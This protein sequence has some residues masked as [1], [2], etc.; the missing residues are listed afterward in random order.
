MP[1]GPIPMPTPPDRRIVAFGRACYG[2]GVAG[3]GVQFFVNRAFVAVV[4]PTMPA[5]PY[6]TAVAGAALVLAGLAVAAA[7]KARGPA[8]WL[9]L[10]FLAAFLFGQLPSV[11]PA[12][13]VAALWTTPLKTLTFAGGA[14]ICAATLGGP[15]Q[16]DPF[17]RNFGRGAYGVTYVFF[18]IEHFLYVNFVASL[19]PH[20]IPGPVFWTYFAGAALIASGLG[21][22]TGIAA[23]L[24]AG[25]SGLM[26]FI[27][28][29][30]LHLPRAAVDPTGQQGNEVSSVVEALAF[31]GLGFV[32]W[33]TLPE[34]S[35]AA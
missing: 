14:W 11:A 18:G 35:R 9:G 4:L 15:H 8:F 6:W 26:V 33:R 22:L 32:L 27:W 23:R 2:L 20:W 21:L 7:W 25:L 34:K 13:K 29:L 17:L 3:L 1:S 12:W 30:V 31:S 24:A 19:V 10:G 16:A 28:L 5:P